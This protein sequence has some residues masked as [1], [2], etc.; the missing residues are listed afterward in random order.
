MTSFTKSWKVGERM[1]NIKKIFLLWVIIMFFV[2][3]TCSL[4]YLV[5]QQT[6]RLGANQPPLQSVLDARL[7]LQ[8]GKSPESV[9]SKY[10]LDASQSLDTFVMIFNNKRTPL[11]SSGT[12]NGRMPQYPKG[13]L[14]NVALK[15]EER[16]TW[17]PQK[18]LR[19]ATVAMKYD[20]GFIV[21]ARS[22][23]ETES[24]IDS[25]GNLILIVWITCLV[26]LSIALAVIYVGIKKL[27]KNNDLK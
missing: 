26:F 27:Y 10:K 18:N 1:D 23:H 24:L 11:A 13:I 17:Q 3:F 16:V 8:T 2:T 7:A 20:R 22:L 9:V 21:G 14:K 5:T 12:I 6:L 25:I 4:T 19:Y 15:G